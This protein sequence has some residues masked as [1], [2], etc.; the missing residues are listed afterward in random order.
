[1]VMSKKKVVYSGK[2]YNCTFLTKKNRPI[3]KKNKRVV[4][5]KKII[6]SRIRRKSSNRG[7]SFLGWG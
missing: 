4:I 1:M 7:L 2:A 3:A 6:L 5:T